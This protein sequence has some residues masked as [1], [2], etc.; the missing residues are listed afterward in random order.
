MYPSDRRSIAW[1]Q[2]IGSTCFDLQPLRYCKLSLIE[3]TQ[4]YNR[5]S[6]W[7]TASK[8]ASALRWGARLG[9]VICIWRNCMH[10]GDM[11]IV[12]TYSYQLLQVRHRDWWIDDH[13]RCTSPM[14]L[15]RL[16]S[17]ALR[18]EGTRCGLL[19]HPNS[20]QLFQ[21]PSGSGLW[22]IS[23]TAATMHYPTL[24]LHSELSAGSIQRFRW[25][26]NI[27]IL[28]GKTANYRY[29]T[30][31][32]PSE[33]YQ[34]LYYHVTSW[35]S[36]IGKTVP[37]QNLTFSISRNFLHFWGNHVLLVLIG[38]SRIW[39]RW[40]VDGFCSWCLYHRYFI[41]DDTCMYTLQT[42]F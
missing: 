13:R 34:L 27:A 24:R 22:V 5:C 11:R 16:N 17:P 14:Y 21:H 8:L 31:C 12:G 37:R 23:S 26:L 3:L 19:E 4:L 29:T 35:I 7:A 32:C 40:N 30:M 18:R 1:L 33:H 6:C 25:A 15:Q 2:S 9:L 38:W 10:G 20:L 42:F 41:H 28:F 39:C 36:T